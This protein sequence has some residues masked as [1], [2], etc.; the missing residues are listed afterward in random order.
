MRYV[1]ALSMFIV[2]IVF[3]LDFFSMV[4]KFQEFVSL[5]SDL[6]LVT[7]FTVISK[8]ILCGFAIVPACT[9]LVGSLLVLDRFRL[10]RSNSMLIYGIEIFLFMPMTINGIL[11]NIPFISFQMHIKHGYQLALAGHVL[12]VFASVVLLVDHYAP[13]L[14]PDLP[15]DFVQQVEEAELDITDP[16]GINSYL[17]D[18][19]ARLKHL[20]MGDRKGADERFTYDDEELLLL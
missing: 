3:L 19:E 15:E 2:F 7:I 12:M 4:S 18:A 9:T 20:F 17:D 11:N 14:A 5:I 1:L 8:L 10:L 16:L 6:P 13:P